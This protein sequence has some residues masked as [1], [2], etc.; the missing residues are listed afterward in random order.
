V[1]YISTGKF[2]LKRSNFFFCVALSESTDLMTIFR[3]SNNFTSWLTANQLIE[4]LARSLGKMHNFGLS[5]GD[6]KWGNIMVNEAEGT[7]CWIGL[8]SAHKQKKQENRWFFKDVAR[9]AVDI[10][11]SGISHEWLDLFLKTYAQTRCISSSYLE[12]KICPFVRKI[13]KCHQK[14]LKLP[15]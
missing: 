7:F 11:E 10:M 14:H 15:Q 6:T 9:F 2:F 8:D 12:K 3:N 5:H 13:N 1:G 4:S